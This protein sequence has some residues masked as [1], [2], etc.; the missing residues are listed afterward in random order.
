MQVNFLSREVNY[1][2]VYCGPEA[3]GKKTN[4]EHI[5]RNIPSDLRGSLITTRGKEAVFFDLAPLALGIKTPLKLKLRLCSAPCQQHYHSIRNFVFQGVD[6]IIFVADS[7]RH[8]IEENLETLKFLE[9]SLYQQGIVISQ[10]PLVIQWNKRDHPTAPSVAEL[11]ARINYLRAPTWEAVATTGKGVFDTFKKCTSLDLGMRMHSLQE[12][13]RR[14]KI[15]RPPYGNTSFKK[16]PP[17]GSRVRENFSEPEIAAFTKTINRPMSGHADE[18]R[19]RLCHSTE[20]FAE[21]LGTL[22]YTDENPQIASL[23]GTM[24]RAIATMPGI[25]IEYLLF[26]FSLKGIEFRVRLVGPLHGERVVKYKNRLD[27]VLNQ[28]DLDEFALG[29]MLAEAFAAYILPDY[30]LLKAESETNENAY[31]KLELVKSLINYRNYYKKYHNYTQRIKRPGKMAGMDATPRKC[32]LEMWFLA[33]ESKSLLFQPRREPISL[34]HV[35]LEIV[36]DREPRWII[37]NYLHTFLR[38]F[39]LRQGLT[40]NLLARQYAIVAEN[41][42]Q[43]VHIL[44]KNI[45]L[46][47]GLRSREIRAKIQEAANTDLNSGDLSCLLEFLDRDV[48]EHLTRE[49]QQIVALRKI[50]EEEIFAMVREISKVDITGKPSIARLRNFFKEFLCEGAVQLSGRQLTNFKH[51]DTTAYLRELQQ[52]LLCSQTK[53][54]FCKNLES[55]LSTFL[56]GREA[57]KRAYR[58]YL[59]FSEAR[60]GKEW[61]KTTFENIMIDCVGERVYRILQRHFT[62]GELSDEEMS[63]IINSIVSLSNA[64]EDWIQLLFRIGPP[65]S[66]Q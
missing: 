11:E 22:I 44:L 13:H 6:A 32:F 25:F 9:K 5:Y 52:R 15:F 26:D 58:T 48:V 37:L 29:E 7:Q 64:R 53:E 50:L 4:L 56:E 24:Q 41:S 14:G 35:F 65:H 54:E 36:E 33:L 42:G 20:P 55:S 61:T 63:H 17:N 62:G 19:L 30:K 21:G 60:W 18:T 39:L 8:R 2:I 57:T 23:K 16:F 47:R 38:N 28:S 66:E 59:D 46:E 40:G 49:M 27:L 1:K 45:L 10:V 12:I 3:S 34:R 43:C 31:F 51:F